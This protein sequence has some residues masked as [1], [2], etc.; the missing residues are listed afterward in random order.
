MTEA[1]Y[2][3]ITRAVSRSPLHWMMR[4]CE[5]GEEGCA[6]MGCADTAARAGD[7]MCMHPELRP[8]TIPPLTKEEWREWWRITGEW[9]CSS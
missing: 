2:Q 9:L 6:C 7:V 5:P 8:H 1:R 3:E 4:W